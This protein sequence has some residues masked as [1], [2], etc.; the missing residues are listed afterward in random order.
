MV[1]FGNIQN[2]LIEHLDV[3]TCGQMSRGD[4]QRVLSVSSRGDLFVFGGNLM[5][6]DGHGFFSVHVLLNPLLISVVLPSCAPCWP[7]HHLNTERTC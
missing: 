2:I 4:K 6:L 5:S 1:L 7:L 3:W